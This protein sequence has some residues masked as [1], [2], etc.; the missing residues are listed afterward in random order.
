[1]I[2]ER[3]QHPHAHAPAL[4]EV[5]LDLAFPRGEFHLVCATSMQVVPRVRAV[6]DA[7]LGEIAHW[8]GVGADGAA[9]AGR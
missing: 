7:I 3:A 5:P 8:L 9:P 4:V 2:L 1:M 6:A